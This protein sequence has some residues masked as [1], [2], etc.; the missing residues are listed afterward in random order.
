MFEGTSIQFVTDFDEVREELQAAELSWPIIKVLGGDNEENEPEEIR[1]SG[2]GV[3]LYIDSIDTILKERTEKARDIITTVAR[4]IQ[5]FN[6]KNETA[7]LFFHRSWE[8]YL[9]EEK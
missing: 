3:A 6:E 2:D 1:T 4:I 8:T 5:F 9:V 7:V